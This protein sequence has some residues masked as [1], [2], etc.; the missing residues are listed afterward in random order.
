M[1]KIKFVQIPF[2]WHQKIKKNPS[3]PIPNSTLLRCV[4]T[5][6]TITLREYASQFSLTDEEIAQMISNADTDGNGQINYAQFAAAL[7]GQY[8]AKSI[9]AAFFENVSEY[10][11]VTEA[12]AAVADGNI[13]EVISDEG[14]LT[15][16]TPQTDLAPLLDALPVKSVHHKHISV[17]TNSQLV[18]S[19]L[20]ILITVLFFVILC[21]I[22]S[23]CSFR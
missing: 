6:F 16:D 14:I 7:R 22:F 4:C 3:F 17:I 8:L 11:D 19:G 13:G 21:L 5:K 10:V 12:F 1:L 18:I 15:I 2:F 20:V 23:K 9:M